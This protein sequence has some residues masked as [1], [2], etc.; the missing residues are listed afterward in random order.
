MI[1]YTATVT[2]THDAQ[3]MGVYAATAVDA[4][5]VA[6]DFRLLDVTGFKKHLRWRDGRDEFV[7]SR[8]LAKLQAIHSWATDF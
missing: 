8:Q 5:K 2:K 7:T 3:P 6:A 4:V 1:I